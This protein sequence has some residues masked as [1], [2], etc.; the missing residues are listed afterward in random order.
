[1][2]PGQ[3]HCWGTFRFG[4]FTEGIECK[5]NVASPMGHTPFMRSRIPPAR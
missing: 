1:M 2:I 4:Y 3:E 5:G